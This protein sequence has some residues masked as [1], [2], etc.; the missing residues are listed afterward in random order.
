MK[1]TAAL[2]ARLADASLPSRAFESARWAGPPTLSISADDDYVED[3]T[4][5]AAMLSDFGARGTF[6]INFSL[7]GTPGHLHT[8]GVRRVADKGHEIAVHLI[9]HV[10]SSDW[11]AAEL[12]QAMGRSR[13]ALKDMGVE[14]STLVYPYGVNNRSI[15]KVASRHY[16][17]A[18][19]AWPGVVTGR[20]NR[21]AVRRM[22]FGSYELRHHAMSD[23]PLA[24]LDRLHKRSGWLVAML[25]SGAPTRKD[26]HAHRLSRLLQG[27]KDRGI[28]IQTVQAAFQ[29]CLATTSTR[30][31]AGDG[32]AA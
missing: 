4:E 29:S 8:E 28:Q 17:C 20:L 27:A 6:A 25:H 7:L 26:G 16:S 31:A 19:S 15:R 12:D 3:E 11:S 1:S 22:A 24:W 10:P 18:P 14:I 32:Q 30:Q 23:D 5:V 2:L 21:Y 9:E 13:A